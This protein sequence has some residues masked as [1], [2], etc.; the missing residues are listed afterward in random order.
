MVAKSKPSKRDAILDAMLDIVV[1]R[2]FHDAPMSLIAQRSGASP[3]IIYH[4]FAS[5]EEIVKAV[6]ERIRTLKREAFLADFD[7]VRDP[8][9]VF[10]QIF[11]SLY[12]F[13][14]KHQREMRFFELCEQA[15]FGCPPGHADKDERAIGL[16]KRFSGRSHGGVLRDWPADVLQ[17][18]TLGLVARLA[19]Q[20]K[21]IAEPMLREIAQGLWQTLKA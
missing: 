11:V 10:V 9:Q 8:A 7:P 2:G 20:P 13:Y 5:K 6:Y 17:E 16:A 15:G 14:R 4:Y 18:M 19:A 3:G 12:Q 21:R 1:E